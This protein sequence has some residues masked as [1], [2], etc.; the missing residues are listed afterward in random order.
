MFCKV[1]VLSLLSALR[2]YI[3][4]MS[5]E[6]V[7]EILYYGEEP[8]AITVWGWEV[9]KAARETILARQFGEAYGR[10]KK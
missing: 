2:E 6:E 5:D 9:R 7:A 8:D 10:Q 3:P 1:Y 4:Y